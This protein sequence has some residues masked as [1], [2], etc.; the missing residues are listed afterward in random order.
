MYIHVGNYYL[1][2]IKQ[3]VKKMLWIM[4]GILIIGIL[5]FLVL[6][7]PIIIIGLLI[8]GAVL[9]VRKI[10]RACKTR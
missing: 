2:K 1:E 10:Y 6:L 4:L 5:F 3:E 7:T 8:W 9:I